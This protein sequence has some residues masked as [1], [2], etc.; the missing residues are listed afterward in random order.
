MADVVFPRERCLVRLR[1]LGASPQSPDT[2][3]DAKGGVLCSLKDN[4][5]VCL[6]LLTLGLRRNGLSVQPTRDLFCFYFNTFLFLLLRYFLLVQK[7]RPSLG[8]ASCWDGE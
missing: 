3:L 8:V 6:F 5:K 1:I 4:H 7:A 2:N